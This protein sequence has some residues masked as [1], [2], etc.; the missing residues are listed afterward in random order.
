MYYGKKKV[1]DPDSLVRSRAEVTKFRN[2]AIFN[3]FA[4][5]EGIINKS[6][7]ARQYFHKSQSWLS[8]RING[9]TMCNKEMAFNAIEARE[10]AT[11][12]RDIAAR[13]TGLAAEIEAVA[14]I[15]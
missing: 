15:D 5:L 7:L 1:L 14:D 10:L 4:E 9:S 11:A 6:A 12:F 8:Q 2:G 13:L 3:A